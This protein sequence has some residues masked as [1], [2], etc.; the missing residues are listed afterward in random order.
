MSEENKKDY[1]CP[2]CETDKPEFRQPCPNPDC[3]YE[4]KRIS[5]TAKK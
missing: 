2:N 5:E 3:G 4:D 1:P